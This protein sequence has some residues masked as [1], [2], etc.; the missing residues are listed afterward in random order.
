V[1]RQFYHE[2]K[3][4]GQSGWNCNTFGFKNYFV[5]RKFVSHVALQQT[6]CI[7][8]ISLGTIGSARKIN[9]DTWRKLAGL[10]L[11]TICE[12][13]SSRKPHI[14]QLIK[15][16]RLELGATFKLD[17]KFEYTFAKDMNHVFLRKCALDSTSSIRSYR[18]SAEERE[19]CS[20][21][22]WR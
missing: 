18:L 17:L 5:A 11:I 1:N 19:L 13:W 2:T 3:H 15:A 21:K 9:W 8:N 7:Q 20:K 12:H 22:D 16:Y 6:N 4:I 10:G 14:E